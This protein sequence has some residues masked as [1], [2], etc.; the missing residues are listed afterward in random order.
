L[1]ITMPAADSL[2]DA[3]SPVALSGTGSNLP[4]GG[5]WMRLLDPE[6]LVV[7]EVPLTVTEGRWLAE[8]S[9]DADAAPSGTVFVYAVSADDGSIV[10]SDAVQV[11]FSEEATESYVT[12]DEPL[13]YVVIEA[14]PVTISGSANGLADGS[15]TVSALNDLGESLGESTVTLTGARPGEEEDWSVDVAFEAEPGTRGRLVVTTGPEGMGELSA[16]IPVIFGDP[17]GMDEFVHIN[18][19]LDGSPV[20]AGAT[21]DVI[22]VAGGQPTGGAVSL[23]LVDGEGNVLALLGAV[24]DEETGVW[25]A[26]FTAGGAE[27]GSVGR[28]VAFFTDPSSGAVVAQDGT[29]LTF[30]E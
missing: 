4:E 25:R 1:T 21:F 14:S 9:F 6:G 13:P 7:N 30:V 2:I 18:L 28:V 10:A 23:Q 20:Q 3:T 5:A 24:P 15:L 27:A 17:A 8:L 22:G 26:T 19:P 12:I 16:S 11:Y 29:P